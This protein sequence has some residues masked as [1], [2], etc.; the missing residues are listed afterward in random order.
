VVRR[1]E[2]MFADLKAIPLLIYQY[3]DLCLLACA[4]GVF[5]ALQ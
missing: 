1:D 4:I 2:A 3:G 5:H